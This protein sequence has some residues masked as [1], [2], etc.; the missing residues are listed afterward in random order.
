[1]NLGLNQ[2]SSAIN[3]VEQQNSPYLAAVISAK[4]SLPSAVALAV[5]RRTLHSD[6]LESAETIG[7]IESPLLAEI[8]SRINQ[9]QQA[10]S[11]KNSLF[12]K[13]EREIYMVRNPQDLTSNEFDFFCDRFRRSITNGKKGEGFINLREAF[14]E[15]TDNVVSHAG[16]SSDDPSLF[17]IAAYEATPAGGCFT[18]CDSGCGF[19]RSLRLNPR[20]QGITTHKEAISAV[21]LRQATS[22]L[23]E[24]T[25]GGFKGL[26]AALVQL[27]SVTLLRT[28]DSF[29]SI[30][31]T[32]G[33]P[34]ITFQA[35]KMITGSQVSVLFSTTGHPSEKFH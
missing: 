6:Q 22:R 32:S 33:G 35:S 12:T 30:T 5:Y 21:V 14:F 25:G 29:A 1:M 23:S 16:V 3:I 15:M 18:V 34:Q 13:Q 7:R 9:Q 2:V 24:T 27:N 10:R 19:V 28:G 4:L 8:D 20:W 26:F 11:S 31:T 17:G